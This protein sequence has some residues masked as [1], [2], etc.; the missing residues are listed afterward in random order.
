M[1]KGFCPKYFYEN[2]N[3]EKE[4]SLEQ[5]WEE[6]QY[7]SGEFLESDDLNHRE[8]T[9]FMVALPPLYYEGEFVKGLY[10]SQGVDYIHSLFPNIKEIFHSMA[11]SMWA[12]VPY[13]TKADVYLN[14]YSYPEREEWFKKT[15]PDNAD[16]IFLPLQDADFTN[17]LAR[18]PIV[19][20]EKDIDI[21]CVSRISAQKNLP[22]L[23]R[24][25]MKYH[26]KYGKI[27]NTHLISGVKNFNYNEREQEII[28]ELVNIAGSAK[29]LNKYIQ[30]KGYVQHGRELNVYYSR[31]KAV[32]LTSIYEGKNRVINEAACCNTPVIVYKDLCKYTR[33]TDKAF[34]DGA[35]FYVEEYT[36]EAFCDAIHYVLNNQD[37]FTPRRGYI[38]ENGRMNFLNKCIDGIP[39]YKNNLPEYT[40]GRIQD[41]VWVNLAMQ[42]NY[43][44]SLY[45][46]LYGRNMAIHHTK[47]H[48]NNKSIMDFYSKR[49]GIQE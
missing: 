46:F 21:L 40:Q 8:R 42:D 19:G 44:I 22:L 29:K 36:I 31:A 12:S 48:E 43:Q 26:E 4:K 37:K 15:Y 34:P 28:K 38:T 24:I 35:G 1:P 9:D 10:L 49:F 6:I 16:K 45:D 47:L 27:L 3:L 17:E 41:N 33:G 23:L 18:V 14:C 32:A 30:I 7:Y 20:A 25:L 2:P 11:Y 13:S 39:Y 5:I